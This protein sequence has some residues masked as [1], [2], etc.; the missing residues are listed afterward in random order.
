MASAD[1]PSRATFTDKAET[2]GAALQSLFRGEPEDTEADL[3]KLLTSG[4]RIEASGEYLDFGEFVNHIRWLREHKAPGGMTFT[5]TQF[6]RDGN[7]VA[8]R[9][10][11]VAKRADGTE[12]RVES[13]L[14]CQVA[15]DGRLDWIVEAVERFKAAS[16]N[17][18]PVAKPKPAVR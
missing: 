7:Q 9:H 11:S 18:A 1:T 3:A 4:F 8:E 14:F 10:L 12:T 6:V 17:W 5:T 13:F 2:F 16:D 15:E